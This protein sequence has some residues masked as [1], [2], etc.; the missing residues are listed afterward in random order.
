[1]L[2]TQLSASFD[3]SG[4]AITCVRSSSR[5]DT[6]ERTY[7]NFRKFFVESKSFSLLN[8]EVNGHGWWNFQCERM[9]HV[10]VCR[11]MC[12]VT[13]ESMRGFHQDL[14]TMGHAY[15]CFRKFASLSHPRS[16]HMVMK[17]LVW[18]VYCSTESK[19]FSLS[20]SEVNHL[21]ITW[22]WNCLCGHVARMWVCDPKQKQSH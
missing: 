8:P 2:Y 15:L 18:G 10:S 4:N 1:M 20:N 14:D 11:S 6:M 21:G 9:V 13:Q 19:S 5:L 3:M 7:L 22:W 16:T 12:P 17:L